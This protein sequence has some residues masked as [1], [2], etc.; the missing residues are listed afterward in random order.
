MLAESIKIKM[1]RTINSPVVLCKL[2]TFFYEK[3]TD[4]EAVLEQGVEENS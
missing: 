2:E 4:A 1:Y 3:R